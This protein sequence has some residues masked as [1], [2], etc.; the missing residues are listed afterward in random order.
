[1][2]RDEIC[3]GINLIIICGDL[4]QFR[5]NRVEQAFMPAV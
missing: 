1:M 2:D 3:V 5:R 4:E